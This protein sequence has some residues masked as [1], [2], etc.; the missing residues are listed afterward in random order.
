MD[1]LS[2]NIFV[3]MHLGKSKAVLPENRGMGALL[4]GCHLEHIQA[5]ALSEH[6]LCAQH[7][8]WYWYWGDR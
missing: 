6:L 7:S 5:H 3:A 2:P 1:F 4:G 8:V